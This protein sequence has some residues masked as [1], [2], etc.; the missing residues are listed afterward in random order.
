MSIPN[1]SCATATAKPINADATK[2]KKVAN[3]GQNAGQKPTSCPEGWH[4]REQNPR[5]NLGFLEISVI[6]QFFHAYF[7]MQYIH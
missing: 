2:R 4:H 7:E 5:A 6:N 1:S 3:K